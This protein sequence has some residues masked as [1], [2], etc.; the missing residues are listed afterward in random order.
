[1]IAKLA[2]LFVLSSSSLLAD[3]T[4]DQK[5]SD[6]RQLAGLYAKN[7]GPYQWKRDVLGF[8]LYNI[9]PWLDQIRETKTD[10]DFYDVCVHYVASLQ[11]SHDEFTINSDFVAYL[12]F[13]V[14]IYDSGALIDGIDRSWLPS[15]KYPFKIGDRV[16]SIDG[17]AVEDFITK[18]IPYSVNGS[19]SQS[20]RR[21]LAADNITF[22]YQGFYIRAHE[23]GD[24]S[25]V[26]IE[27][28]NGNMETYTIPWD[29]S[30]TP[31][32]SAGP[33]TSPV[34]QIRKEERPPIERARRIRKNSEDGSVESS[35]PW[36]AY[37]GPAAD[38]VPYELPAYQ[39]AMVPNQ[40]MAGLLD[41][42]AAASFGGRSPVFIPPAGFQLR[43]GSKSTDQFLSAT[44]P[45]GKK[46]FGFIRIY[47]MSPTNTALA[48][49]QFQAEMS[50][51]QQN[52]DGLMIDLMRNGGG[53]LC[54][55]E[56][57]AQLLMPQSFRSIPE[58]IRATDFWVTSFSNQYYNA[59]FSGAAAWQIQSY[60]LFL[61]QVRQ[62][63]SENRGDTGN[64][65]L[66]FADFENTP[67]TTDSSRS[68]I[69][70]SK[71]ILVLTDDFTLSAAET[72]GAILQDN[73]RATFFGTRTD[74]GGGNVVSYNVG[75]YGEGQARVTLGLET[76][77]APVSTPGFP[78]TNFIENVGIYPDI[79]QDF[80]TKENL[81][82]SGG[83][84]VVN[85]V[86][87]LNQLVA[88]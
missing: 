46:T 80:M 7:Y 15:S 75:V 55:T 43:L 47:T 54:Y 70:Y 35:N 34:G 37:E 67:P 50:Y 26:V 10:L 4:L 77:K 69:A 3:L 12:H 40:Q 1:M 60:E 16:V 87:A 64:I 28:Q 5:I 13:D 38:P 11:D 41:P 19:G 73:Q 65:P 85:A 24:T 45:S 20:T 25:T 57:L 14:D 86:A 30:G 21:R 81:L 68:V 17:I 88:Q 48:L 42:R 51:F 71:P 66:C 79:F 6:F 49:S 29:K 23:I 9:Q 31:V 62:A 83:T 32:L 61:Q 22:R 59:P 53:S 52:T 76:R 27:R 2:I 18:L 72:L 56:R 84:F 63:N 36:G 78:P 44:F 8:D 74:G 58:I 33:V 39:Q 82:N